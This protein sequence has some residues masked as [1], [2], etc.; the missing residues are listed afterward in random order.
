MPPK[1]ETA[2]PAQDAAVSKG[3]GST[4]GNIWSN[5]SS[6]FSSGVQ[7]V[8]QKSPPAEM[9]ALDPNEALRLVNGYRAQNGLKPVALDPHATQA[10]T[11]NLTRCRTSDRMGRI[12]AS[13]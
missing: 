10:A 13:A 12:S 8:S 9:T 7:P 1:S 4:L 3:S 11:G 2:Q 6:P 5:F